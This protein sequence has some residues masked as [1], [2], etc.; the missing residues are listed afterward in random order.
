MLRTKT[1]C[2]PGVKLLYLNG[3]VPLGLSFW[4]HPSGAMYRKYQNAASCSGKLPN[5]DFMGTSTVK[6]STFF[7]PLTSTGLRTSAPPSGFFGLRIVRSV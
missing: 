5:G 1:L 6:S 2:W 4:V 3:P 7:S